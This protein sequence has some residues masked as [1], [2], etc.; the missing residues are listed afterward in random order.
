MRRLATIAW[1]CRPGVRRLAGQQLIGK[2]GLG[3]I[4]AAVDGGV[5][6]K[7]SSGLM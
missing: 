1:P 2:A 6:E 4:G 3:E 5:A 7:N